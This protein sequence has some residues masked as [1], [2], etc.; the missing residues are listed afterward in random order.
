[1]VGSQGRSL[2]FCHVFIALLSM[3]SPA[4][5]DSTQ[6]LCHLVLMSPLEYARWR[7][8]CLHVSLPQRAKVAWWETLSSQR[9]D[10]KWPICTG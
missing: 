10:D 6:G 4:L 3:P 1:M 5:S 7:V 9:G 2:T 8:G